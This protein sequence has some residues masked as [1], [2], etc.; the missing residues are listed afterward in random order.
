MDNRDDIV[1]KY[2]KT[3]LS[4]V[5]GYSPDVYQDQKGVDTVGEGIS[6]RSPATGKSLLNLGYSPDQIKSGEVQLNEDEL[7][8]TQD[9]I[10]QQKRDQ[11]SNIKSQSFPD[12]QFNEAQE[13]AMLSLMYN[14]PQLVGPNIRQRLNEND[15]LGAMKEILLNSNKE[16]SPGLQL[17]RVK[18]A[19]LY[20][21]PLD[22][23]QL[24]KTLK[25]EEKKQ[26]FDMLNKLDNEEHRKG[27]L[28]K[29]KQFNPEEKRELDKP[30][31]FKLNKL[32]KGQ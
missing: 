18:E 16:Q 25:P 27:A 9:D 5:E 14:S 22:F 23:Q 6:L 8:K 2:L 15:D 28:E 1:K 17:R 20:G 24:I 7:Q 30:Q 26:V 10:L 13:A 19:E 4:D 31:F 12:K 32:L 3:H 11:F 29:Y 21:G